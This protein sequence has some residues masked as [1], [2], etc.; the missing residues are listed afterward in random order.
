[1]IE[2]TL[3]QRKFGKLCRVSMTLR[4]RGAKKYATSRFFRFQMVDNKSVVN[5]VQ[6][7]IMIVGKLRSEE[8]KMGDNLIVCGII[9]KLPPSWKEFQ[10]TMRLKQK[11]LLLRL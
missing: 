3:V 11:E 2:L 4:R 10:K 5:Q 1:M 7:F 6:D 8:V 9:D